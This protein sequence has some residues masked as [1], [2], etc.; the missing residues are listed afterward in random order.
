M[1]VLG[2]GVYLLLTPYA[3][4]KACHRQRCSCLQAPFGLRTPS[5][6]L[7]T[8]MHTR[9]HG[10]IERPLMAYMQHCTNLVGK[11]KNIILYMVPL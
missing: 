5:P 11:A 8:G 4:S 2:I 7:G 3:Q 10:Q 9:L 6:P 1:P